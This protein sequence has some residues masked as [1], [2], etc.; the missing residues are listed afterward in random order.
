MHWSR[1]SGSGRK[2][3]ARESRRRRSEE[4]WKR[5]STERRCRQKQVVTDASA[6]C[7]LCLTIVDGPDEAK[8]RALEETRRE[9]EE[10]KRREAAAA[11]ESED[12][13]LM[14]EIREEEARR[15]A[16]AEEVGTNFPLD[17]HFRL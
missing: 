12:E 4:L 17:S 10:A 11:A 14:R 9:E 2:L 1:R 15:R 13:R 7:G 5:K 6:G 16:A 3:L 8:R